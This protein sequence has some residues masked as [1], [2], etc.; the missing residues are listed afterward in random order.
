MSQSSTSASSGGSGQLVKLSLGALGVVYGDIGTSPLYAMR[1]CFH[2]PHGL[3][4]QPSRVLGVVSLMFW[5]MTLLI[6]FKYISYVMRADNRGEGGVLALMALATQRSPHRA[7]A[8][9]ILGLFGAALLYGD[10]M[11]TPS[12]SVLSAM[13]GLKIAAPSLTP[14]VVPLTVMVLIGIFSVQHRGTAGIGAIFGPVTLLWFLALAALGIPWIIKNPHVLEAIN[15]YHGAHFLLRE[16]YSGF[17][18]LGSVFLVV[19]GGES[20]YADMGHFGRRP[21]RLTWFA[22][23]MPC[24]LLHYFGQ[25]AFLLHDPKGVENPFFLMAPEWALYPLVGLSTFATIIASQAVI[26]GAFSITRQASML[27]FWPRVKVLH[28]SAQEIGQVYVPSINWALMVATVA[29]VL[30]FRTSSAL[31]AA[32]GIAVTLTMLITTLL[33]YVVARDIWHW[34][35]ARAFGL[36]SILVIVDASFFLSN[37]TKVADGG[38]FP[39]AAAGLILTLMTTWRVGRERL[40]DLLF[41]RLVS[42]EDFFELLHVERITRVP[43]AAVYMASYV[44]RAPT[45][46]MLNTFHHRAVHEQVVLLTIRFEESSRINDDERIQT[47]ELGHGF[48]RVIARFGFMEQPDVPAIL[49]REDTPT[50][51]LEYTTFFL[52][53]ETVLAADRP[54]MQRWRK[55]LFAFM[56]RNAQQAQG[57]FSIPSD[58]VIEV[59]AQFEL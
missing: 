25:A 32:Y 22:L 48:T 4:F 58:R 53:R 47:E 40:R 14:Y 45:A 24:L 9:V 55:V 38:W 50:P 13:E 30:G 19:T 49:A 17:L 21:I 26:S 41:E 1:E 52:G 6:S 43:G 37:A 36:S 34:S 35:R 5:A 59:G 27:G 42:L 15:P 46:L 18:I 10:G 44:E 56:A 16:G 20:I 39:I 31:A 11:I 3:D 7:R 51:P 29:L 54:G 2:G 8:L 57:F 33:A 23:V 28:T 12:I